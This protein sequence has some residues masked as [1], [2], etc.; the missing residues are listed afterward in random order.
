MVT[1]WWIRG[2]RWKVPRFSLA[3]NNI[4]AGS[5]SGDKSKFLGKTKYIAVEVM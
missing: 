2:V 1:I 5:D 3:D 4:R